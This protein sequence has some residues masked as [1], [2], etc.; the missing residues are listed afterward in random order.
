MTEIDTSP[1]AYRALRKSIGTQEAVA[2]QLGI[3]KTALGNRERGD[4]RITREMV[5]ALARLA[6][7]VK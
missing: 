7:R 5:L 1:E 4:T 2:V 6:Q 3:S